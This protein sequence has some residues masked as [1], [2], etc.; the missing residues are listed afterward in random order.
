MLTRWKINRYR[1]NLAKELR[2]RNNGGL[3]D[4]AFDRHWVERMIGIAMRS[5]QS[6]A[7]LASQLSGLAEQKR[8]EQDVVFRR[9]MDQLIARAKA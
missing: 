7:P 4:S 9:R 2:R 3:L 5:N 8:K 6:P 1:Q